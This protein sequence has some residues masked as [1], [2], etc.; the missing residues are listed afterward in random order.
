VG[1]GFVFGDAQLHQ[2]LDPRAAVLPARPDTHPEAA[3]NPLVQ[4]VVEAL[5]GHQPKVPYP[6]LEVRTKLGAPLCKRNTAAALRDFANAS[7]ELVQI[8]PG[9][10]ELAAVALEGEAEELDSVSATDTALLLT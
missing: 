6:A 1:L 8:L 4:V 10:A 5:N 7:H 2:I 3:T 9:N